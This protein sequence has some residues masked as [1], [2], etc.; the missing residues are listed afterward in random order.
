MTS[1][2]MDF[3]CGVENTAMAKAE[4]GEPIS[5]DEFQQVLDEAV[6]SGRY[7]VFHF[8]HLARNIAGQNGDVDLLTLDSRA[9]N[10]LISAAAFHTIRDFDDREKMNEILNGLVN[11]DGTA[12]GAP[13]V[14]SSDRISYYRDRD[15][16]REIAA[17][18]DAAVEDGA[19]EDGAVEDGVDYDIVSDEELM[20][21]LDFG[22]RHSSL[23]SDQIG[24]LAAALAHDRLKRDPIQLVGR[25]RCDFV[26]FVGGDDSD[27]A[28][29]DTYD[30][31]RRVVL[32]VRNENGRKT[33]L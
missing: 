10:V 8:D 6:A 11:A 18:A 29:F 20:L 22:K 5:D 25:D 15:I 33:R 2:G 23:S 12:T 1:I 26:S 24:N 19:V 14:F 7:E 13:Y 3:K 31:A 21:F 28:D 4:L 16:V 27:Y 17:R 30:T 9:R 32:C